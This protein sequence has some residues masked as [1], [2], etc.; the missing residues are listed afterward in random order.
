MY[1]ALTDGRSP[2][3]AA[4]PPPSSPRSDPARSAPAGDEPPA[5]PSSA[6]T[7]PACW[8]SP[9]ATCATRRM[10]GTP[11]RRRSS[12]PFGPSAGSRAGLPFDLAH[13]IAI[14]CCLMKLRRAAATRRPPSRSCCP[15]STRPGTAFSAASSGP[16]PSSRA[17]EAPDARGRAG[18]DRAAARKVPQRDPPARHRGNV[19]RGSGHA[20]RHDPTAVKVRLHRAR[21]ALRKLIARGL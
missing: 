8:P 21:Q 15:P 10:P 13:R 4:A 2:V 11:S 6:S 5:R 18:G 19:D 14:N 7:P 1:E 16:N 12:R 3:E 9:A 20:A 17:R